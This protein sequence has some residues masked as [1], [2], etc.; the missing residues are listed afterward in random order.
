MLQKNI[1]HYDIQLKTME[2]F[3]NFAN[4][5]ARFHVAGYVIDEDGHKENM[6]ELLAILSHWKLDEL[7]LELTRYREEE[8]PEIEEY[9][10]KTGLLRQT[11]VGMAA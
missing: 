10:R 3:R 9:L 2:D 8:I 11:K 1:L 6:Y 5:N 4:L 7:V